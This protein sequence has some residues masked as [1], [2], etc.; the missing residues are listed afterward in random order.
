MK[1]YKFLLILTCIT[2]KN[3]ALKLSANRCNLVNSLSLEPGENLSF[4]SKNTGLISTLKQDLELYSN[5]KPIPGQIKNGFFCTWLDTF[6]DYGNLIAPDRVASLEQGL[7]YA[8]DLVLIKTRQGGLFCSYTSIAIDLAAC[9]VKLAQIATLVSLTPPELPG[10]EDKTSYKI[11]LHDDGFDAYPLLL[12]PGTGLTFNHSATTSICGDNAYFQSI[13]S[14]RNQ[15]MTILAD[16]IRAVYSFAQ[17]IMTEAIQTERLYINNQEHAQLFKNF[18]FHSHQF[19]KI[20]SSISF[21]AKFPEVTY[22]PSAADPPTSPAYTQYLNLIRIMMNDNNRKKRAPNIINSLFRDP[23]VSELI[24]DSKVS[25]EAFKSIRRNEKILRQ[26]QARLKIGMHEAQI[27]EAKLLAGLTIQSKKIHQLGLSLG[28]AVR[29][30]DRKTERLVQL[31]RFENLISLAQQQKIST[32]RQLDLLISPNQKICNTLS[33]PTFQVVCSTH[34]PTFS[35]LGEEIFIFFEARQNILKRHF[36]LECLP[37]ANSKIFEFSGMTMVKKGQTFYTEDNR[38]FPEKCL[39]TL[40]ECQPFYGD[41]M[42]QHKYGENCQFITDLKELGI[43]CFKKTTLTSS[44]GKKYEISDEPLILNLAELP[45]SDG[46][47]SLLPSHILTKL[48]PD[49]ISISELT[50]DKDKSEIFI[51][52][53]PW[54]PKDEDMNKTRSLDRSFQEFIS[55]EAIEASH[56]FAGLSGVMFFCFAFLVCYLCLRPEAAKCLLSGCCKCGG[57]LWSCCRR[58]SRPAP[59]PAQPAVIADPIIRQPSALMH[60]QFSAPGTLVQ[61]AAAAPLLSGPAQPS[62][63]HNLQPTDARAPFRPARTDTHDASAPLLQQLPGPSTSTAAQS[64]PQR[65]AA[66]TVIYRDGALTFTP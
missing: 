58:Q 10:D 26:N 44:S 63:A 62:G 13:Q 38:H 34:F 57:A 61:C 30:L 23:K 36:T 4:S 56:V 46:N 27:S 25:A 17:P 2:T 65:P 19:Y 8:I 3:E 43:N 16:N 29:Y 12:S 1:L 48:N 45:L 6:S 20:L 50:S 5:L 24:S 59:L 66:P 52:A 28:Y 21:S 35:L 40:A 9:K 53:Q 64:T 42:P 15:F 32:Q 49:I 47:S 51:S 60:R 22:S 31:E 11:F 33:K 18:Q 41:L 14:S 7:T 54:T 37:F 55:P 39:N